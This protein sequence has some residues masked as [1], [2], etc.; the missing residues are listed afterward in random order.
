M[1]PELQ[2]DRCKHARWPC[3]YPRGV[4]SACCHG[5]SHSKLKC[6][7][8]IN[9]TPFVMNLY[10]QGFCNVKTPPPSPGRTGLP[11]PP[12]AE[13]R[14]G[15][16]APAATSA[17]PAPTQVETPAAT[18]TPAPALPR[19]ILR[20]PGY[21]PA[22][23]ES[24]SA[25]STEV[26]SMEVEASVA[27]RTPVL[28]RGSAEPSRRL[29]PLA[30]L[31]RP[32]TPERLSL[33]PI[34]QPA[35]PRRHSPPSLPPISRPTT[36]QPRYNNSATPDRGSPPSRRPALSITTQFS[37]PPGTPLANRPHEGSILLRPGDGRVPFLRPHAHD[38]ADARLVRDLRL[39]PAYLWRAAEP[40]TACADEGLPSLFGDVFVPRR[41]WGVVRAPP[42]LRCTAAGRACTWRIHTGDGVFAT[43]RLD[44]VILDSPG[45]AGAGVFVKEPREV[46]THADVAM[47]L[48][49]AEGPEFE[50][51]WEAARPGMLSVHEQYGL[52][53]PRKPDAEAPGVCTASVLAEDRRRRPALAEVVKALQ[54]PDVYDPLLVSDIF[55]RIPAAEGVEAGILRSQC[56]WGA[57]SFAEG[58]LT[59]YLRDTPSLRAWDTKELEKVCTRSPPLL[60]TTAV[61]RRRAA[62]RTGRHALWALAAPRSAPPPYREGRGA[63]PERECRGGG[64][65]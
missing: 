12:K 3:I 32:V 34:S 39:A 15:S 40:C 28:P 13:T 55:R 52:G 58:E 8:F 5:C 56:E 23:T 7:R 25:S 44:L 45:L 65:A 54:H 19:V 38:A 22:R 24:L 46:C 51:A 1:P 20:A 11:T 47:A 27:P 29:P 2:C 14:S 33:P 10:R 49:R 43:S 42:C 57:W 53:S 59:L 63:I 60:T 6:T 21:T 61:P 9:P 62:L 4:A 41:G 48:H 17:T 50:L 26:D 31:S 37:S 30:S 36:P 35:T 64:G 16:L 18:P